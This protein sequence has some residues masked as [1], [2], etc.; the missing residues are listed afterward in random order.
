MLRLC[1]PFMVAEHTDATRMARVKA[2]AVS[3][4]ACS[5]HR[6]TMSVSSDTGGPLVDFSGDSKL[7]PCSDGV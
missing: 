5:G 6:N 4:C 2:I 7:V 3:Y 1:S